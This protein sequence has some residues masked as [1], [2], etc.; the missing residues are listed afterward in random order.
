MQSVPQ[1]V[2]IFKAFQI[3]FKAGVLPFCREGLAT[4]EGSEC[5]H[6]ITSF[7]PV[8]FSFLC[9]LPEKPHEAQKGSREG[10]RVGCL[11]PLSR[12]Y[13]CKES[14]A[15]EEDAQGL[16]T[17]C[18]RAHHIPQGQAQIAGHILVS[19]DTQCNSETCVFWKYD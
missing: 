8:G 10:V 14:Q 6:L 4:S 16:L 19:L 2:S 9:F 18:P 15:L 13:Y 17:C 1:L 12:Q 5:H 3:N 11:S 7:L